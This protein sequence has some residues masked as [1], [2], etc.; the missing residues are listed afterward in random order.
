MRIEG[1]L[2][3]ARGFAAMLEMEGED[4]DDETFL[5]ELEVVKL[6]DVGVD[7]GQLMITDP[8][9][10]DSEWTDRD[11]RPFEDIRI[12]DDVET[13]RVLQFQKDFQHYEQTPPGYSNT[14]NELVASGRLVKRELAV[15]EPFQYS[16]VGACDA[17]LSKGY[18]ELAYRM[19][20]TGAGVAFSTAFGDGDYP[21]YG[22]KRDGRIVRVYV[23]VA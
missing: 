17:T 23:N 5:G 11:E 1:I 8:C 16:Y 21:I 9:Y 3:R 4:S 7:S 2:E 18:G 10:I 6:G 20:H 19:G 14:V 15:N 13:G 12:Y 22:E